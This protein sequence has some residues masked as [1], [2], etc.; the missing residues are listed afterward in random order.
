MIALSFDVAYSVGYEEG[1]KWGID[2]GFEDGYSKGDF[3]GHKRGYDEGDSAGYDDG[4][5]FGYI[6]GANDAF[7]RVRRAID[8]D[9]SYSGDA[10]L[11]WL[12]G[13]QLDFNIA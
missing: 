3:A 1:S 9:A 8:Y 10:I 4:Y 6:D 2:K 7:K 5:Y 12:Q 13:I 11:S